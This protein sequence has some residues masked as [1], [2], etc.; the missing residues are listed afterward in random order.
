MTKSKYSKYIIAKPKLVRELA[1]HDL[2]QISGFTFPDE[3]Y[4]DKDILN[5]ANHWLDIVWIWEKTKPR[6]LPVI[7]SHKFDEIVLLIG[8][9]PG[10]CGT[11]V[12]K[13]NIAIGLNT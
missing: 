5:E 6:E 4:L 10:I 1:D 12:E 9:N 7:H 8:S 11:W 3:V 13:L 2:T